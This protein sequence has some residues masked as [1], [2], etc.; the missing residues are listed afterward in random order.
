MKRKTKAILKDE[1]NAYNGLEVDVK[2]RYEI[3]DVVVYTVEC[4]PY[5][6]FSTISFAVR[7]E[8]LNFFEKNA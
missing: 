1:I 5:G 2:E 8:K 6:D 3:G 4:K 7:E